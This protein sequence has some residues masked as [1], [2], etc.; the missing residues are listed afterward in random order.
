M[1][2]RLQQVRQHLVARELLPRRYEDSS[3]NALPAFCMNTHFLRAGKYPVPPLPTCSREASPV[4]VSGTSL[5]SRVPCAISLD[6]LSLGSKDSLK[7]IDDFEWKQSRI[8]YH[9]KSKDNVYEG[10]LLLKGPG[11]FTRYLN[12]AAE[13]NILDF[14]EDGWFRTGD[15]ALFDGERFKILGRTSV[16]IIKTGGY[17]VSALHVESVILENPNIVDAA[18]VGI[19]NESYGEIVAAVIVLKPNV[20]MTLKELK[21]EAGKK[22][23]PYQLPKTMLIVNEMPRNNMGKLNKKEIKKMLLKENM[24][25][26]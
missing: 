6:R 12:R 11:V 10:E 25:K 18:V 22:L 4:F 13:L 17:K 15:I 14:T 16:D 20:K 26:E 5:P 1:W 23:A 9:T 3:L 7:D 21:N 8:D 24:L 19:E 2:N